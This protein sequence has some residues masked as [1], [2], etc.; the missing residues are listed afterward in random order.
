MDKGVSTIMEREENSKF[1]KTSEN[2]KKPRILTVSEIE[3]QIAVEHLEME[4]RHL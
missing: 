4:Q 3:Q 1:K 2:V